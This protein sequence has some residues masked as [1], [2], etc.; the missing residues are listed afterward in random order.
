MEVGHDLP[1]QGLLGVHGVALL[2]GFDLRGQLVRE[3]QVPVPHQGIADAHGL[4]ELGVGILHEADV[5]AEALGHLLHAVQAQEQGGREVATAH[6]V[7]E[8]VVAPQL[9][10]RLQGDRVEGLGERV[11]QLVEGDGLPGLHALGEVVALQHLG[12]GELG[13]QADPSLPDHAPQP[14]A[15][16]PDPGFLRV[17]KLEDLG[18]VGLGVGQDL[19]PGEGRAGG[20]LAGGVPDEAGEIPDE[21]GH[22]VAQL[23]ELRHL[24][25]EHAV[26]QVQV[27]GRGI[28]AGLDAERPALLEL[29]L[30]L[31]QLVAGH[32]ALREQGEGF[33][34]GSVRGVHA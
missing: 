19:L 3:E 8:L 30:Q 32:R 11:E 28:E 5:V 22:L 9:H 27:R 12:H 16:E 25:D 33:G 10:V 17:Q 1:G 31:L 18:L 2:Q 21:E 6:E 4:P 14:L 13:G 26:P 7:E 15:V 29:G 23:L 20:L 24:P 34:S